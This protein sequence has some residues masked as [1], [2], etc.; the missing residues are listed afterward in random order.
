M[1]MIFLATGNCYLGRTD[2]D[3]DGKIIKEIPPRFENDDNGS[4]VVIGKLNPDTME[5][6]GDADVFGDFNAS[7]YLNK[8]LK[9][10]NPQ[11]D[12]DIPNF[13]AIV[14]SMLHDNIDICDNCFEMNC[15]NCI[16]SEW[17][18]EAVNA[19]RA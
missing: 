16:V 8:A 14:C 12:I 2:R 13:K 19:D 15:K 3:K 5:Q 17:K 6:I 10:L 1:S 18:Q 9:L 7:G 11:R 4:C